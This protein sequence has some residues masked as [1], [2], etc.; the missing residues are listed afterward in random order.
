VLLCACILSQP[1]HATVEYALQTGASLYHYDNPYLF[2]KNDARRVSSSAWSTDL[3]AAFF[4]PM[5]SERS[6]LLV[7]GSASKIRFG[8]LNQLDHTKTQWDG[9]YQWELSSFLRGKLSHRND[10]RMYDYY[11]GLGDGRQGFPYPLSERS[12][13]LEL[14]HIKD[15]QAEIALRITPRLD[16]PLTYT[17]QSIRFIDEYNS[18]PYNRDNQAYQ[19]AV[20]YEPGTKSR[21]I[22]GYTRTHTQMPDR[23]QAERD[24]YDTGYRDQEI[25]IDSAWR[26][27]ENTILLGR[28]GTVQRQFDT[29]HQRR[30]HAIEIG[31]DWHYSVKTWFTLRVWDRPESIDDGGNK[32]F[33]QVRGIQGRMMWET[34]PKTRFAFLSSIEQERYETHAGANNNQGYQLINQENKILRLGVRVDYDITSRLNLRLE[35]SH[36]QELSNNANKHNNGVIGASIRYSFENLTGSNRARVKLDNLR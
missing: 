30:L 18:T 26:A 10:K 34:T 1:V 19:L 6:H 23:T 24:A 14:P 36:R 29:L 8:A 22:A 28:L 27:T 4:V 13:D 32:L 9:L 33:L 16:V 35:A 11:E 2:G 17:R 20:R 15:N 25:F 3:N 12:T 7:S 21:L 5:P 31:T